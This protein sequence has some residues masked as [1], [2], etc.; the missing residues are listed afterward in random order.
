MGLFS[1]TNKKRTES[2]AESAGD[3]APT[4]AAERNRNASDVLGESPKFINGAGAGTASSYSR[5]TAGELKPKDSSHPL[6]KFGSQSSKQG[7]GSAHAKAAI[8]SSSSSFSSHSS[9]AAQVQAQGDTTTMPSTLTIASIA[10]N[11]TDNKPRPSELFAG[12]GVDW[13]AIS[14][15]GSPS[16]NTPDNSEQLQSFLKARR[17]WIPS[18]STEPAQEE[19]S[20][21]MLTSS[22]DLQN[23]SF[24]GG[25]LSSETAGSVAGAASGSNA[26]GGGGSGSGSTPGSGISDLLMDLDDLEAS[27]RRKQKLLSGFSPTL[28]PG[29]VVGSSTD[30][31]AAGV[32][33]IG[34][35]FSSASAGKEPKPS[36]LLPN[37]T[38]RR[39]P[40]VAALGTTSSSSSSAAVRENSQANANGTHLSV[41]AAKSSPGKTGSS[42]VAAPVPASSKPVVETSSSDAKVDEKK[43]QKTEGAELKS[44][45]EPAATAAAAVAGGAAGASAAKDKTAGSDG[46]GVAAAHTTSSAPIHTTVK[47]TTPLQEV[48]NAVASAPLSGSTPVAAA[49]T[50]AP[51]KAG[52]VRAMSIRKTSFGLFGFGRKKDRLTDPDE[53]AAR[54]RSMEKKGRKSSVSAPASGSAAASPSKKAAAMAT[55]SGRKAVPTADADADDAADANAASAKA[56][57]AQ[58]DP[59]ETTPAATYAATQKQDAE[60]AQSSSSLATPEPVNATAA[61]PANASEPPL[62]HTLKEAQPSTAAASPVPNGAAAAAAAE[63]EAAKPGSHPAGAGANTGAG[64][65]VAVAAAA[66]ASVQ[67]HEAQTSVVAPAVASAA[68]TAPLAAAQQ[69]APQEKQAIILPA[70]APAAVTAVPVA[71]SAPASPQTDG[72]GTCRSTDSEAVGYETPQAVSVAG[73]EGLAD[74]RGVAEVTA[75]VVALPVAEGDAVAA[76]AH[77]PIALEGAPPVAELPLEAANPQDASIV[78][79]HED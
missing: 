27:H 40:A 44:N 60:Q 45:K 58:S 61:E 50:G 48:K 4:A 23:I 11:A 69:T 70:T 10:V 33:S 55:F 17:T 2:I 3:K 39:A 14:L 72:D 53:D 49:A 1:R 68:P 36:A 62:D 46:N 52:S 76:L 65:S 21:P 67:A 77:A 19:H 59:K 47:T 22:K 5:A 32:G 75:S 24:G 30:A 26:A 16:A 54:D 8:A 35:D 18:F 6:K 73:S 25:P 37:G 29:A 38:T 71:A 78:A 15:T 34:L 41:T 63:S 51:S 28:L 12:K 57:K 43:N 74:A 42:S 31:S 56:D 7:R 66:V 20:T 64:A 79:L 13:E 9:A